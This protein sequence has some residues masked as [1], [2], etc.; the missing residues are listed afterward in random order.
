M[1]VLVATQPASLSPKHIPAADD[2]IECG[3]E[4]FNLGLSA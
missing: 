1:Q 3:Q 4:G 2:K